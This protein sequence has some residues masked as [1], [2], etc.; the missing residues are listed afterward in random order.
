MKE[1]STK[2]RRHD[3]Y[4]WRRNRNLRV[5]IAISGGAAVVLLCILLYSVTT[6][7]KVISGAQVTPQVIGAPRLQVN[8]DKIEMGDVALGKTVQAE[9]ELTNTGDRTLQFT[10]RPYIEVLEGC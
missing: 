1:Q 2:A 3:P 4:R 5:L 10:S 9:F 6:G 8:Q 7:T